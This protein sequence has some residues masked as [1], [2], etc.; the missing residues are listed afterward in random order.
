VFVQFA[1]LSA[2]VPHDVE[3]G[4]HLC[5]GSPGDQP[6]L[7]LADA[8]VLTELVNGI[9]G[10][11]PRPVEYIHIPVPKNATETFFAPLR[12]WR[13]P[14]GSRLY[15]GLLQHDDETGDRRRIAAA[16]QDPLRF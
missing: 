4:F 2:A 9:D 6:L 8:A 3:L 11:V 14:N 5:Y 13:R 10:C 12:N 7:V 1:R 15:L 16:S